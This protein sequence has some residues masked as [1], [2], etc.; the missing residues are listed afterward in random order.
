MHCFR[1]FNGLTN[2]IHLILFPLRTS[3]E[4]EEFDWLIF[5]Y[6]CAEGRMHA[7]TARCPQKFEEWE[8]SFGEKTDHN[9]SV[10][11]L[12]WQLFM[13]YIIISTHIWISHYKVWDHVLCDVEP[14][15]NL[16]YVLKQK[17]NIGQEE[18]NI[19]GWVDDLHSSNQML[20]IFLF[21]LISIDQCKLEDGWNVQ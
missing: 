8:F 16:G 18:K 21:I 17:E 19:I 14:L 1:L 20:I 13:F 5:L 7:Q 10:Q 15:R 12:L 2:T 4:M 9:N 6:T 11:K 3:S